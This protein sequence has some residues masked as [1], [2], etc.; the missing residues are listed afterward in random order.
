MRVIEHAKNMERRITCKRCG[1]IYEYDTY[2]IR[3][4][5]NYGVV[6]GYY[7]QSAP[8]VTCPDCGLKTY[9]DFHQENIVTC[10]CGE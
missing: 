4:D 10:N 5:N 3:E 2:D 9:L 7:N 1:C 6:Y 8:Y